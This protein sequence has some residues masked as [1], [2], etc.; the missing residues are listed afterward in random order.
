MMQKTTMQIIVQELQKHECA[1]GFDIRRSFKCLFGTCH[2]ASILNCEWRISVKFCNSSLLHW[3]YAG[4][5]FS[6]LYLVYFIC[7]CTGNLSCS[8]LQV[9]GPVWTE[10]ILHLKQNTAGLIEEILACLW[11]LKV[12][13]CVY[14]SLDQLNLFYTLVPYFFNI[15]FNTVFQEVSSLQ[16]VQKLLFWKSHIYPPSFDHSNIFWWRKWTVRLLNVQFS[17][18]ACYVLWQICSKYTDSFWDISVWL[19]PVA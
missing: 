7:T 5:C 11:N 10:L 3:S 17:Q 19:Q 1:T 6:S 16:V 15:H 4:H 14:K 18:V 2:V 13:Y 9:M 8:W 12:H